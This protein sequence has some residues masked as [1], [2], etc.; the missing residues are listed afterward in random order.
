MFLQN[1]RDKN[2]LLSA[3]WGGGRFIDIMGQNNIKNK[4]S[5]K[6]DLHFSVIERCDNV[7]FI[8]DIE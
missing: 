3:M 4:T 6:N 8:S 2:I 1:D 7:I 5:M